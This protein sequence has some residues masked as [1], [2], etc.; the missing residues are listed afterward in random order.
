V[1]TWPRVALGSVTIALSLFPRL[2]LGQE[3]SAETVKSV[4]LQGPD[5]GNFE[6]EYQPSLRK[7]TQTGPSPQLSSGPGLSPLRFDLSGA[8][9][10]SFPVGIFA[11]V[12]RES[13][14]L[15]GSFG[16]SSVTL[17]FTLYSV[18]AGPAARA[19]FG[20][21]R[22]LGMVGYAFDDLPVVNPF[23]EAVQPVT[24]RREAVLLALNAGYQILPNLLAQVEGR[25][26]IAFA[27]ESSMG[28]FSS[29][30]YDVGA[31]VSFGRLDLIGLRWSIDAHYE[32]S[33]ER[34]SQSNSLGV[35]HLAQRF[36]L[37]LEAIIP[38][39]PPEPIALVPAPGETAAPGVVVLPKPT[40]PQPG[41]VIG[42]VVYSEKRQPATGIHVVIKDTTLEATTD[43]RGVFA[44]DQIA[45]GP[46]RVAASADG[47]KP[48][49]EAVIVPSGGRATVELQLQKIGFRPISTLRGVVRSRSGKP[50]PA[51]LFIVEPNIKARA[52][53]D[54]RFL[55]RLP[56]GH[57]TVRFE[58]PGYVAQTKVVDVADGDEAVFDIDLHARMP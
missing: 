17:P 51:H 18:A 38:H 43:E 21:F 44:I 40:G 42:T 50:L 16:G 58:A 35:L 27:T 31:R 28:A 53:S 11:S 19:R 14:S 46:V 5:I 7:D 33:S 34:L 54:G 2:S 3:T 48:V 52:G 15:S 49:E 1:S 37:G 41:S 24:V 4:D 6:F 47:Y 23:G 30:E 39:A 45:P 29:L 56:G 25:F 55:I 57:Y 9:F 20:D 22:I 12:A 36:G 8:V 13:F 10:G 26:P 32:F